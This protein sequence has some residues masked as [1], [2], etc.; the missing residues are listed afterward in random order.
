MPTVSET[1][2]SMSD[3]D[4]AALRE[5]HAEYCEQNG[6]RSSAKEEGEV[7]C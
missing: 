2:K 1:F 6:F 3:E 7:R 4:K 5:L